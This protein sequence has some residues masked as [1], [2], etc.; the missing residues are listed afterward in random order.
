MAYLTKLSDGQCIIIVL[1]I[2]VLL[3]IFGKCS[4]GCSAPCGGF[5][6]E[7]FKEGTSPL[8]SCSQNFPLGGK[9]ANLKMMCEGSCGQEQIAVCGDN[10]VGKDNVFIYDGQS[11]SSATPESC[12]KICQ[13]FYNKND[14]NDYGLCLSACC[15]VS[16]NG[17]SNRDQAWYDCTCYNG[18][19]CEFTDGCGS[20]TSSKGCTSNSAC[21]TCYQGFCN[22]S[23]G[24][25]VSKWM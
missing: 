10:T 4:L 16:S 15:A 24:I 25:Q 11:H 22:N 3:F 6:L 21:P 8:N 9:S 7:G 19:G 13:Q 14:L 23:K 2:L 17:A 18:L 1:I 20:C 5:K 12:G